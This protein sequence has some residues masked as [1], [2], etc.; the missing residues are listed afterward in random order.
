M[1]V[2]EALKRLFGADEPP[3]TTALVDLGPLKFE[4]NRRGIRNVR[5]RDVELVRGI[6]Y[7]IRDGNWGTLGTRV[8]RE[9]RTLD[10]QTFKWTLQFESEEGGVRG[11][12]TFGA[13]SEGLLTA[14]LT[15]DMLADREFC[16][17]GFTLLHPIKGLVGSPMRLAAPDGA[18]R[19]AEF[20]EMISPAQPASG[21]VVIEY[22]ADSA[23]VSIES[24]GIELE[25]ED[26]R[27]WSDASFKSYARTP[28]FPNAYT[29]RR[30]EVFRH[31]LTFR[32]AGGGRCASSSGSAPALRFA[33]GKNETF[34]EVALARDADWPRLE[35]PTQLRSLRTVQ[36]LDLR[37]EVDAQS[38]PQGPFDLE[39]VV[40]DTA[41]E[42]EPKLRSL[43]AQLSVLGLRPDHVI[44]LPA[45]Y[46]K[47]HQ[48]LGPWPIG[49]T[50]SDAAEAARHAFPDALIGG[51]ALTN[52]TEFNR[53]PPDLSKV[54]YVTHGSS[55]T[56]HAADDQSVFQTLEAFPDIFRSARRLAPQRPYR[57]G[58]VSI[59]MRTN[60]YGA[61][62]VGNPE[63]V[64]KPMSADEPRARAL[65]GA[66]WL[67]GVVT[68]TK[69]GGVN[70]LTPAAASGPFGVGSQSE[71]W[72]SFHA[73]VW[74]ARMQNRPRLDV[75]SGDPEVHAAAAECEGGGVLAI[76][77][78]GSGTAKTLD[79]GLTGLCSVLDA[80][81]CA[82]AAC[83]PDWTRRSARRLQE[84]LDLPPY[85]VAFIEVDAA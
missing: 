83:D 13:S 3:E 35:T 23:A 65:F 27:N 55:A 40:S 30:G 66:A 12:V 31:A 17:T 42:I 48:P 68:A 61:G 8:T 1:I 60:P 77:A 38:C 52:F 44:A 59:G 26:Q 75:Q 33:R 37:R 74:F 78:N 69:G 39:L 45:A 41:A 15:L 63:R 71:L 11:E 43:A 76:V 51:G 20:P 84:R 24:P 14:E 58:L 81:S 72:P 19:T 62:L 29:V 67:V 47:S 34:P 16:R 6:D 32:F 82:A 22:E 4:T 54:D 25:M 2:K 9:E 50:P 28:T 70:L 56:V 80:D 73:I 7:P 64:R 79:A 36:R 5:W 21:F 10:A 57:L 18:S 46:L 49:A 85:A 53:H